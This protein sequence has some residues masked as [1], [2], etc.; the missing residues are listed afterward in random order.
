MLCQVH[1]KHLA[2]ITKLE[3]ISVQREKNEQD[4]KLKSLVG[5]QR[6]PDTELSKGRSFFFFFFCQVGIKKPDINLSNFTEQH[7]NDLGASPELN[8]SC[9]KLSVISNVF[10]IKLA[11]YF[12]VPI[13]ETLKGVQ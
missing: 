1:P 11:L 2:E 8:K 6:S 5:E 4:K 7:N 3:K 10:W 12:W 9:R 13:L